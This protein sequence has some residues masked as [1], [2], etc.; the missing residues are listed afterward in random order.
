VAQLETQ[1]RRGGLTLQR[2]FYYLQ[3][4]MRTLSRVYRLTQRATHA[5]VR[6]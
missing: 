4:S 6:K 5:Q 1:Q 3:P 2:L